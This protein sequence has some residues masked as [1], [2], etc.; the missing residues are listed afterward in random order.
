MRNT[1]RPQPSAAQFSSPGSFLSQRSSPPSAPAPA[2]PNPQNDTYRAD[3]KP[4]FLQPPT[5]QPTVTPSAGANRPQSITEQYDLARQ[6]LTTPAPV[7]GFAT[8]KQRRD[9]AWQVRNDPLAAR[10]T[11]L[12]YQRTYQRSPTPS[13]S[14]PA[15][16]TNFSGPR[17]RFS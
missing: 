16:P 4:D 13:A 17:Q 5:Q 12:E 15:H 6:Q 14:P 3:Y 9:Y 2:A 10:D 7:E 8:E 11:A 1:N